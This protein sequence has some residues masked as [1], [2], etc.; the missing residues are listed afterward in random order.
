[1]VWNYED[2]NLENCSWYK[3]FWWSRRAPVSG[4]RLLRNLIK[5]LLDVRY[6]LQA[7]HNS[8]L[9]LMESHW[10]FH[11]NLYK[12]KCLAKITHHGLVYYLETIGVRSILA[13]NLNSGCSYFIIVVRLSASHL[14]KVTPPKEYKKYM[15]STNL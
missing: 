4:Q 9:N 14:L 1:M 7:V 6:L 2:Y 12:F 5:R 8:D 10:Y 11:A 13:G 15:V 3:I